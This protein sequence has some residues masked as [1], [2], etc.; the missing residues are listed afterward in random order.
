MK[1]E[2]THKEKVAKAL[3]IYD[4]LSRAGRK[5]GKGCSPAKLAHLRNLHEA[6]RQA[7]K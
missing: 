4:R 6:R 7:V 3:L 5:G 2:M 1:K